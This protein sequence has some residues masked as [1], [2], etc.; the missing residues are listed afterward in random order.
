MIA[1]LTRGRDPAIEN[2]TSKEINNLQSENFQGVLDN[3][4]VENVTCRVIIDTDS[5]ITIVNSTLLTSLNILSENIK[6]ARNSIRT[7]TGEKFP[8][9]G[10][11]QTAITPRST[12]FIHDV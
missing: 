12:K 9:V 8:F 7:V 11:Q 5:S 1:G 3:A 6:P 10:R 2:R 4:I